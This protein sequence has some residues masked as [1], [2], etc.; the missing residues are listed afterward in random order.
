MYV[1]YKGFLSRDE[2]FTLYSRSIVGVAITD[3]TTYTGG[4]KGGL[5]FGK[6]FEFMMD[7]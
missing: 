2:L 3:Y 1:D 7:G 6:N 5:G 4:R